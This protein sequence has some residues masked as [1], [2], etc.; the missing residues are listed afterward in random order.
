MIK[1]PVSE[2][3]DLKDFGRQIVQVK[4]IQQDHNSTGRNGSDD[5]QS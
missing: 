3:K 4:F 2:R 1:L 5:K